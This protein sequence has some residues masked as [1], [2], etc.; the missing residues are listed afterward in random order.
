[1]NAR[2][3]SNGNKLYS[4]D[5]RLPPRTK[6]L[7]KEYGFVAASK[8]RHAIC[9]ALSIHPKTPRQ[10]S[11]E[12]GISTAHVSRALKE[13]SKEG[14]VRCL[15]PERVKGRLY[16]LTPIGLRVSQVLT[17]DRL[18]ATSSRRIP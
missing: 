1:M 9:L 5:P 7:W 6:M 4:L 10:I 14:L 8:H 16:T 17:K 15:N 2:W 3:Y 12:I 11:V 18:A 13:L